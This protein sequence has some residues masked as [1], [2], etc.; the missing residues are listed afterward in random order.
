MSATIAGLFQT[1]LKSE[2]LAVELQEKIYSFAV[3]NNDHQLLIDL[4]AH[5]SLSTDID[6]RIK[7]IDT[8]SVKVAWLARPNRSLTDVLDVLKNEK[9]VTLLKVLAS[10]DDLSQDTYSVILGNSFSPT[11]LL[12]IAG[13]SAIDNKL[14]ESAVFRYLDIDCD[15]KEPLTCE[16]CSARFAKLFVTAPEFIDS[17]IQKS[18]NLSVL[19]A[20]SDSTFIG[21]KNQELLAEAITDLFESNGQFIASPWDGCGALLYRFSNDIANN[22]A[23]SSN[24]ANR[25]TLIIDKILKNKNDQNSYRYQSFEECKKVL[26]AGVKIKPDNL[27]EKASSLFSEND[28][29]EFI[30]EV[31]RQKG[32]SAQLSQAYRRLQSFAIAVSNNPHSTVAQMEKVIEWL[33]WDGCQALLKL[34]ADPRKIAL[35]LVKGRFYTELDNSLKRVKSPEEVLTHMIEFLGNEYGYYHDAILS[36]TYLTKNH[37]LSLPIAAL[38]KGTLSKENTSTLE[39]ILLEIISNDLHWNT[40]E[41]IS[42]EFKGS[43]TEVIALAKLL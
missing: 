1:L 13:N 8:A 22:G 36:S 5:N 14:R 23:V 2:T 27:S 31:N 29:D 24:C 37:L 3:T 20:A 19:L 43:I 7:T 11:L 16:K 9:R 34:L 40:F 21:F 10:R 33:Q 25:L 15:H 4:L 26:I 38:A 17:V 28:V 32:T 41:H 6:S 35:L 18:S 39:A 42:G 30:E 12:T